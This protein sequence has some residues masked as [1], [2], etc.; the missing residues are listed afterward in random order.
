M[1]TRRCDETD[2]VWR[3]IRNALQPLVLR[4]QDI[5]MTDITDRKNGKIDGTIV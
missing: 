4:I 1:T 5:M 2:D 3:V